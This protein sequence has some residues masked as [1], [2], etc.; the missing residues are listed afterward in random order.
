MPPR[1]VEV[2]LL[3]RKDHGDQGKLGSHDR[4]SADAQVMQHRPIQLFKAIGP[5]IALAGRVNDQKLART[6]YVKAACQI[7]AT[8]RL[9][10]LP[11][12]GC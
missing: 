7:L 9:A 12:S 5:L 8:T 3:R 4:E 11:A 2:L 6:R 10:A 1:V